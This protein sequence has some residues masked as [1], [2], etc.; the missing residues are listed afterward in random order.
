MTATGLSSLEAASRLGPAPS[1]VGL[2]GA[3][4]IAL[5]CPVCSRGS[6]PMS[7]HASSNSR[8]I[9]SFLSATRPANAGAGRSTMVALLRVSHFLALTCAPIL[10][11]SCSDQNGTTST[12]AGGSGSPSA[13]VGGATTAK[14]SSG[15]ASNGGASNGGASSGGAS[16]GGASSGG[17]SNGGASSGGASNGGASNGGASNGGAS[18][19]GASNGGASNGGASNGGASNGG[20]SSGGASSGGASNGGASSGGTT[21][22]G[23]A[24]HLGGTSTGTGSGWV[25]EWSNATAPRFYTR[26]DTPNTVQLD[27]ADAAARDGSALLLTLGANPDPRPAGGAEVGT[28]ARFG[29]GTFAS[30]LRTADCAGQSNAGVV[31][32]LFTYFNDGKD[33]TGD[34]LP[35]NSEIDFEW[36]CAEPETI[37]LTIWT[38]YRDNDNAQKR[39]GRA[40]NLATGTILYTCYYTAFG[41]C[42]ETL[43]GVEAV[44]STISV[45]AGYDS[46]SSY[47]EYGFDWKA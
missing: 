4:T 19:G 13:T 18:N 28:N 27:V 3:H 16:N 2:A 35:D 10:T 32:G 43:K 21:T 33:T 37:Y 14:T 38:D 5:T 15:G 34:G 25:E 30:R 12:S 20:A 6:F 26:G 17:A 29:F 8:S 1:W 45:L 36:L 24:S 23:G 39:V 47:Y 46:S 7:H 11:V 42:T 31:T 44:P 22:Y 9:L 41:D 40:I